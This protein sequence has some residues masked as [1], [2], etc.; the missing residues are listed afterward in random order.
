M[1]TAKQYIDTSIFR[2]NINIIKSLYIAYVDLI[3]AVSSISINSIKRF[4]L[5]PI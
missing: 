5:A 3:V 4:F 1:D 2:L